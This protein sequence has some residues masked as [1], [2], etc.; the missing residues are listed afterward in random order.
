MKSLMAFLLLSA[1]APSQTHEVGLT[2][3]RLSG[4]ARSSDAATLDLGGGVALQANY[5]YRLALTGR[6]AWTGEVHFLAN[7]QRVIHSANAA[8]TRDVATLFVT[9]GLRVKYLASK[10]FAP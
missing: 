2:L 3:G 7:G 8:T 4:P 10:R 6:F 5:G 1:A 9:P